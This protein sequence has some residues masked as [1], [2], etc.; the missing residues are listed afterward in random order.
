[1]TAR[2]LPDQAYLLQCFSYNAEFGTLTWRERPVEHFEGKPRKRRTASMA[3]RTFNSNYAGKLAGGAHLG[4]T[5]KVYWVVGINAASFQASRII[6]MMMTDNDPSNE[7]DHWNGDGLDDSWEN[8]REATRAQNN[9][10][11]PAFGR[12]GLPKG[13]S[14]HPSGF[15]ARVGFGG[16]EIYLG[17][18]RTEEAA[19][20]A[21]TEAAKRL[22]GEFANCG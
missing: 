11:R 9:Q 19:S 14:R 22:H 6:W 13:V 15:M 3:Q 20:A 7:I 16:R 12:L 8:L 10:N 18:F 17:L 21:H 4:P 5:G 1:M 2:S